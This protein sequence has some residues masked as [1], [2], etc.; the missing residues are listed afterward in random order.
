VEARVIRRIARPFLDLL[1]QGI[2]P[3]KIALTIA[4]GLALGV[5]PVIGST[6]LLCTLAAAV[7]RLNLPAIQLVNGLA[8]PL[9]LALIVP[10]LRAG[11]WLFHAPLPALTVASLFAQLHAGVWHAVVTLWSATLHALVAWV[12]VSAATATLTYA[13]ALP[14]LRRAWRREAA[15]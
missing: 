7:L 4:I 5:T 9:Q 6:T 13:I 1:R 15:Q 12:L 11:A 8:Y 3:E 14:L 2:A 10:F